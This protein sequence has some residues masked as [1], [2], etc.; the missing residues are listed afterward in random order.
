MTES[1]FKNAILD[2]AKWTGWLVHHD[3]PSTDQRGKWRTHVQG[4]VGFP[5]LVLLHPRLGRLLVIEL[6]AAKGRA[7][8]QQVEWLEG[9]SRAGIHAEVWKPGDWDRIVTLLKDP[10][11][12][13]SN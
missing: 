10:T 8:P 12:A 11:P 9:F 2:V 7:T 6:K 3:L 5:D 4:D 13:Q 1:E